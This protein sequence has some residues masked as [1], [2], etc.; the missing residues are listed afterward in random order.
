M[1]NDLR[2][3]IKRADELGECCVIEGA[4]WDKEIGAIGDLMSQVPESPLLVFDK[5]KGY[6]PG[7]RVVSNL[8]TSSKRIAL[9]FGLPMEAKGIELVTAFR[10]RLRQGIQPIPPVEV[11][12]GPVKENVLVGDDVD[13]FKFPT[14]KWHEFDGGRY[15]GTGSAV[16]SRD[17]DEGWVNLG[18]YRV[19]IQDKSTVT[20]SLGYGHHGNIIARKYWNK[21]LPCPMAICCGQAPLVFAAAHFEIPWRF[22]EYDWAGG[23]QRK[24][25]EVTRGVTTDLPIPATAEIV[26]EGEIVPPGV[27]NRPEGPFG[28]WAGYYAGGVRQMPAF[29]VKSILHRNNPII[30]GNPPS[31]LPRV[32][33]LGRH[34]QIAAALWDELDRQLPGVKGVWTIEETTIHGIVVI[35]LQQLYGGHAKQAALIAAGA[36]VT[37]YTTRY[38]IVVDEDIDPSNTS[39]VL[40]ALGTR[41]EPQEIDILRG[42]WGSWANPTI[43]PEQRKIDDREHSL[44]I[45]LACKPYKWIKDFPRSTKPSPELAKKVRA[46]WPKLFT[47]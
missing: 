26:L 32:W 28:E 27:D 20:M 44:G 10:D 15:I 8:A 5:I 29:R 30:Q 39:E 43:T 7:Y 6:P 47:A 4:D 24:P 33:T 25:I 2:E 38:I 12:T 40:W 21:G 11:D 37:A 41:S 16:V 46:K 35:A 22:P 13:L 36:L 23:W 3:F 1:F 45:I 34:I 42:C 18:T 17:P 19:Q 31:L 9:A 14:P